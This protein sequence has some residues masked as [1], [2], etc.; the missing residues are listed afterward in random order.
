MAKTKNSLLLHP[1]IAFVRQQN[2]TRKTRTSKIKTTKI[3]SIGEAIANIVVGG[4]SNSKKRGLAI[5]TAFDG[6]S[7]FEM[8]VSD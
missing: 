8:F 7:P 4:S 1:L 2:S 5:V 3:L 6:L